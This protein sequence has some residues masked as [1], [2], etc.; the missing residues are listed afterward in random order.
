MG[1]VTLI[2]KSFSFYVLHLFSERMSRRNQGPSVALGNFAFSFRGYKMINGPE[3]LFLLV[4]SQ[5][6]FLLIVKSCLIVSLKEYFALF[7]A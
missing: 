2:I 3:R 5:W 1:R 7:S 4:I 6:T